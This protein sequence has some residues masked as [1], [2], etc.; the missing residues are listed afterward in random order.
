MSAIDD[1]QEQIITEFAVLA[2]DLELTLHHLIDQGRLLPP[3][4]T[5]EQQ[6]AY[7][8]EGCQSSVWLLAD[9]RAGN[10][11]YRAQSD[12]AITRGLISLLLRIFSD[13]PIADILQSKLFFPTR[14]HMDRFIGTQRTS[15]FSRMVMQIKQHA[16]DAQQQLTT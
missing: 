10:M 3:L 5:D 13:R 11:Y 16:L 1:T 8:V 9:C 2:E 12:A 15:G 6:N 4:A 14:I 7:L